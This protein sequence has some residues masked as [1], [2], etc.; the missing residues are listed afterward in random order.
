MTSL[1]LFLF[2][3]LGHSKIHVESV[4]RIATCKNLG[5]FDLWKEVMNQFLKRNFGVS[6]DTINRV[7][8]QPTEQE[9]FF[10][11]HISGKGLVC[12]I[13]KELQKLKVTKQL[14]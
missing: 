5:T 12:R 14:N 9:K 1:A 8:R 4:S 3:F 7:K 10:A 11:N 2:N 6:K 13:D